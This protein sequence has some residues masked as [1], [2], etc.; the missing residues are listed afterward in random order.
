[1]EK[2][3]KHI[4]LPVLFGLILIFPLVNWNTGWLKDIG[5]SENRTLAKEPKFNL[6]DPNPYPTKF[7]SFFND[8][9]PLRNYFIAKLS[10]IKIMYLGI[11]PLPEKVIIGKN[12]WMFMTMND[13]ETHIGRDTLSYVGIRQFTREII[14]RSNFLKLR[15]CKYYY[16]IVPTKYSIYPEYLPGYFKLAKY[17]TLSDQI[18]DAL[19]KAGIAV[20][21][22]RDEL[23]KSKAGDLKGEDL[24]LKSDNHWNGMGGYAASCAI[25]NRIRDDFST[26]APP[27]PLDSFDIYRRESMGGNLA[28]MINLQDKF[29]DKQVKLICKSRKVTYGIKKG[30]KIPPDFSAE[31]EIVKQ[32]NAGS[33]LKAMI[34]RDSFG[35]EMIPVF[36]AN[37]YQSIYIFDKWAYGLN[38]EIVN[39][40]KP[41][42][43]I[44][45]PI[46]SLADNI[47]KNL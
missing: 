6:F 45:M 35:D 38:E 23:I 16:V 31:F 9:F 40:E 10:E 21:D 25:I 36:S 34:I 26:V 32:C 7:D 33:R 46:E 30:Y 14:R 5:S 13:Y 19:S 20:I 44:Q 11:S 8:H 37:F 42:I 47:W 4:I 12:G 39:S 1:M 18:K 15:N 29:I 41:D 24:F 17:Y 43:F 28:H 27:L 2:I 22:L 3:L